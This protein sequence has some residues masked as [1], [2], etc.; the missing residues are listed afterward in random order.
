MLA[1]L[2]L[3]QMLSV[4]GALSP[5]YFPSAG[6]VLDELLKLFGQPVF[7]NVLGATMQAW[8]IGLLLAAAIGVPAGIILGASSRTYR[9]F[10]VVIEA[11]RPVPPVVLIPIA[12]LLLGPSL[13][14]QLVLVV[15]GA[16]WPLLLQTLYGARSLDSVA[17]ETARSFRLSWWQCLLYVRLPSAMPLVATGLRISAVIALVVSIVAELVGGAPGLGNE[18]LKAQSSDAVVLMYSLIVAA[19]MLGVL[20]NLVFRR[21]ERRVLFW[22]PSQREDAR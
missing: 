19:G 14:M 6:A 22:H 8:A 7:W 9:F 18:I 15:Q 17:L 21:L 4:L 5:R 13:G 11:V 16:V 20:V 1:A 12:L 3:W 2:G 10:R